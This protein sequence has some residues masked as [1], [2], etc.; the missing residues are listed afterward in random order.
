MNERL[1]HFLKFYALDHKTLIFPFGSQVYGT[2]TAKSDWDYLAVIPDSFAIGTGTEYNHNKVNVHIYKK[3]DWQD[4]LNQHKIHTLEAYYLPDNVCRTNFKFNL[5]LSALR[6]ELSQKASNSF[7]KAK[8]KIEVEKDFLV[9]WKSLFH[10]LRILDFGIQIATKGCI[11]N[12]SSCNLHWQDIINNPQYE[13]DY[14]KKKYQ[15]VY[16]DL[17]TEFRKAAPK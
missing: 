15:P 8:K 2:C 9:G 3:K 13:W 11:E 14:Y 4:Q 16:N 7:V 1:Q 17:A 5:S 12:Y 10:S 6:H